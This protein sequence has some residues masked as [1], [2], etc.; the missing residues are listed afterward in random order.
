M[1]FTR[2]IRTPRLAEAYLVGAVDLRPLPQIQAEL[3]NPY[4]NLRAAAY[5][6]R[7]TAAMAA[8]DR[9]G[10]AGRVE[11]ADLPGSG[12]IVVNARRDSLLVV[13]QDW[14]RGWHATVDGK[15]VPVLRTDGLVIGLTVPRGHHV[16]R[17]AFT[18]PGLR[19]GALVTLLAMLALLIAAP[20]GS[21]AIRSR[22]RSANAAAGSA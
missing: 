7:R 16:V 9:P 4:A 21:L 13:S 5:V 1:D 18:P 20:L 8:L 22:Q 6:E 12:R 2:W 11:S 3:G 10:P 14:E 15:S 17:I 19:L